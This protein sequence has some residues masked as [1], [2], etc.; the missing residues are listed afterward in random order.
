[1]DK[2]KYER[3]LQKLRGKGRNIASKKNLI[4]FQREKKTKTNTNIINN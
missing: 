1:M 3:K 4:E 2:K